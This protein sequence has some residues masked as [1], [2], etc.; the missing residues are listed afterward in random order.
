MSHLTPVRMMSKIT[1]IIY[2]LVRRINIQ[3]NDVLQ[4]TTTMEITFAESRPPILRVDGHGFDVFQ[5]F[6]PPRRCKRCWKLGHTTRQCVATIPVD[7]ICCKHCGSFHS[8]LEHGKECT[9]LKKC[10]NCYGAHASDSVTCPKYK[11]RKE[12]LRLSVTEDIPVKLALQ[13]LGTNPKTTEREHGVLKAPLSSAWP[14][15]PSQE[16]VI[17]QLQQD[18]KD[19]KIA[20]ALVSQNKNR[21]DRLEQKDQ[22]RDDQIAALDTRVQ[23]TESCQH[24][25]LRHLQEVEKQRK[26]DTKTVLNKLNSITPSKRKAPP[27]DEPSSSQDDVSDS[28]FVDALAM[29]VRE[30]SAPQN[31]P[32]PQTVS[33][34]A[35]QQ[36]KKTRKKITTQ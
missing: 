3:K 27:S 29:D 12:A 21:I 33:S 9:K 28:E 15:L 23:K 25:I 1:M 18:V 32:Q 20:V 14:M 19:L 24:E 6:P 26:Q 5:Y 10:I 7:N 4:P 16:A 17:E 13:K 35:K 8:A 34:T 36:P 30:V 2:Q 11:E 31:S 22:S